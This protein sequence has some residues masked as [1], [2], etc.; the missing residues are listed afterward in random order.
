MAE[1]YATNQFYNLDSFEPFSSALSQN[2]AATDNP[3]FLYPSNNLRNPTTGNST[4]IQRGYIRMMSELLG[5][6][7]ETLSRRRLHFQFNP[8]SITRSV[9]ARN[10]IQLWMNMDPAQMTQPVP[11]D[12]NFA[13]ELLFNREAEVYSGTYASGTATNVG[14]PFIS[15]GGRTAISSNIP[16][17]LPIDGDST[18][19]QYSVTDIGV[20][21]DL[22]VF[23]ELIGQGLNSQLI[24]A[25]IDR[26]ETGAA[27]RNAQE[28]KAADATK[29]DEDKTTTATTVAFNRTD[30]ENALSANWG[31]SAF[32]ISQPIRVVLSS[33]FIVEGYVTSTSVMF[34]KFTPTMVPVQATVGIQMQAMYMGFGKKDTFF[35]KAFAS[36]EEKVKE[37]V[38]AGRTEIQALGNI[39]A[40]LFKKIENP[41]N[42]FTV[43]PKY[44]FDKDKEVQDIWVRFLA[45]DN[46][47]DE[48]SDKGSITKVT[49]TANIEIKYKGNSSSIPAEVTYEVGDTVF[50]KSAAYDLDTSQ[51]NNKKREPW[52]TAKFKIEKDQEPA[53]E[54]LDK[55]S[56][57]KY[58]FIVTYTTMIE[59]TE[60]GAVDCAQVIKIDKEVS[61][62]SN[63]K[64]G[65]DAT[66]HSEYYEGAK[67]PP[68][69][70]GL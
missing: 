55:T 10:D 13:F 33:L 59:G 69:A 21:A 40:T 66:L 11:G 30:T 19:G 43:Q 45:N 46:L 44:F 56:T 6:D 16:A 52:D 31:N 63:I 22:I 62:T 8:D 12:A 26:A 18:L 4:P 41:D 5:S 24:E 54:T 64:M 53:Q 49:V 57:S 7:Y 20:L 32:L 50:S 28:A 48:I 9:S 42:N 27:Y 17:T 60:G 65:S 15:A 14:T 68:R 70:G 2:S 67:N 29:D 47:R 25:M 51:L 1:R 35:T 38:E 3:P 61:W 39:G 37:G 34:N 36:N 58:Q 23:D